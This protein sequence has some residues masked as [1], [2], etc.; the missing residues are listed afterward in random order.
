MYSSILQVSV[1]GKN[2]PLIYQ[3][4]VGKLVANVLEVN[5]ILNDLISQQC[6]PV[7]NDS[8]HPSDLLIITQVTD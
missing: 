6:Q 1:N 4:L 3:S 2:N 8:I 7:S 5:S